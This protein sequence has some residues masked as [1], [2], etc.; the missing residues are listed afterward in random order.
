MRKLIPWLCDLDRP[1]SIIDWILLAIAIYFLGMI[2]TRPVNAQTRTEIEK[3]IVNSAR[4]HKI[5]P[6][7]ALAIAEVESRFNPQAVGLVGEV[8]IFQLRPEYHHV[9][10][11]N[12]NRN[13]D[14][15]MKYLA[16][17]KHECRQYGDAYFVCFNYGPKRKL[18]H[19]RL[20]PYYKKVQTAIRI[21]KQQNVLAKND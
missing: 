10:R 19:P 13:V 7:L 20:F 16:Q 17:L 4:A 3:I 1:I 14:V 15:A 11:G 21:R 12:V 9:S 5:N 2:H 8:G 18:K 6:D